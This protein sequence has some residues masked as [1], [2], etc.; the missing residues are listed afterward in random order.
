MISRWDA[1]VNFLAHSGYDAPP[2]IIYF[3][4]ERCG[5][6]EFYRL[7]ETLESDPGDP[8]QIVRGFALECVQCG[9]R[10]AS[11]VRTILLGGDR[12]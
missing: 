8:H 4:C 6:I 11:I 12:V 7:R 3:R 10:E 9:L 5:C 1:T 2:H